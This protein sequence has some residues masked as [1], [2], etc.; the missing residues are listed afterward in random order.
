LFV[1]HG[2]HLKKHFNTE[3][4]IVFATV[5]HKMALHTPANLDLKQEKPPEGSFSNITINKTKLSL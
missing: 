2:I 4:L 5:L 1:S 3:G